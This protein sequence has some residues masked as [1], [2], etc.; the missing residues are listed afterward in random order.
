MNKPDK[1]NHPSL[2]PLFFTFALML[3]ALLLSGCREKVA[4]TLRTDSAPLTNRLNLPA[5]NGPVRWVAYSPI[6][7][8]GL[9]PGRTDFFDLYVYWELDE[10]AWSA[11]EKYAGPQGAIDTITLPQKVT[12]TLLPSSAGNAFKTTVNGT[13]AQG[14]SF[15]TEGLSRDPK[16]TVQKA[17]RVGTTLLIQMEVR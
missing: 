16:T 15:K 17:I 4:L 9:I 14:P 8:S 12:S 7:T 11:L 10:A 6:D 3:A 1:P 5:L 13:D 2:P